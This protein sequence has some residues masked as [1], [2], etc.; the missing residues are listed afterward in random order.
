LNQSKPDAAGPVKVSN[1]RLASPEW[2]LAEENPF[3]NVYVHSCG[4]VVGVE[5]RTEETAFKVD[6]DDVA[7]MRANIRYGLAGAGMISADVEEYGPENNAVKGIAVITKLPQVPHGMSYNGLIFIPFKDFS[8]SIYMRYEEGSFTGVRETAVLDKLLASGEVTLAPTS[9]GMAM[10]GL[11]ED[12]YDPSLRG[13]LVRTKAEREEYDQSFPDHPLSR[14]RA[15]LGWVKK[16]L[17]L[18]ANVL[19]APRVR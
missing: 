19:A 8:Y 11:A 4:D 14:L 3:E 10:E 17:V 12:L 7:A 1:L 13:P 2:T 15:C 18:D 6:F 5:L 16:A 9:M